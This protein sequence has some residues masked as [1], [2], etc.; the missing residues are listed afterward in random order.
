MSNIKLNS[1]LINLDQLQTGLPRLRH[2]YMSNTLLGATPTTQ[3]VRD[4]S[5]GFPQLT[6][7][8]LASIDNDIS[9]VNQEFV[10]Q[11]VRKSPQLRLLDLR[12]C[13]KPGVVD[14][15]MDIQADHLAEL[16]LGRSQARTCVDLNLIVGRV[17]ALFRNLFAFETLT[18]TKIN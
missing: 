4:A 5:P 17:F 6:E 18:V 3:E 2:L 1:H 12:G 15:L 14:C 7:L 10:L 8:S 13:A 9:L 11:L 16:Y